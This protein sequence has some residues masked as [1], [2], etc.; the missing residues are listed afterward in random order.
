MWN[1]VNARRIDGTVADFGPGAHGIDEPLRVPGWVV[2]VQGVVLDVQFSGGR[3]P[4]VGH[5]VLVQRPAGGSLTAEVQAHVGG[6]VVRCFSFSPLSGI[7]R[8][9]GE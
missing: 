5:A 2:A 9:L 7:S 3:L 1:T 4:P 6:D 8:R